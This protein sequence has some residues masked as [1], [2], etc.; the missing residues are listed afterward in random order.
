[1]KPGMA[2]FVV[3]TAVDDHASGFETSLK[4]QNIVF[5]KAGPKYSQA[6]H[7]PEN[8]AHLY[9]NSIFTKE[10]KQNLSRQLVD[11]YQKFA[12]TN[13]TEK[14]LLMNLDFIL[15]PKSLL[16]FRSRSEPVNTSLK[17]VH[18]IAVRNENDTKMLLSDKE[19]DI[20]KRQKILEAIAEATS[21]RIGQLENFLA[22]VRIESPDIASING[23]LNRIYA[24]VFT[25]PIDGR[26]T[27]P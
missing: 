27:P 11:S 9:D 5:N 24:S 19:L 4:N 17:F 21:F 16:E 15:K 23:E 25:R 14:T 10:D 7:R 1:M 20:V 18:D 2:H 26:V 22:K 12:S 6:Y 3:K 13:Q 8:K